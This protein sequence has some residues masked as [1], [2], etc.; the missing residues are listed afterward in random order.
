MAKM[1]FDLKNFKHVKSD[2][3]STVLQHKQGHELKIAHKNL[4]PEFKAQLDALAKVSQDSET[5]LQQDEMM[6]KASGGPIKPMSMPASETAM[7][8]EGGKVPI[9]A[10][11]PGPEPS[12]EEKMKNITSGGKKADEKGG[13]PAD[14]PVK[15]GDWSHIWK[16]DGGKVYMD[17]GGRVPVPSSG[18]ENDPNANNRQVAKKAPSMGGVDPSS[19]LATGDWSHIWKAE[20]GEVNPKLEQSKE[21]P[22]ENVIDYSKF[23]RQP[24]AEGGTLDYKKLKEEKRE[25]NRNEPATRR[26][27][28][29]DGG[30]VCEHCGGPIKHLADGDPD[31]GGVR[32]V[33]PEPL[34]EEAPDSISHKAIEN[35]YEDIV[36]GHNAGFFA[37]PEDHSGVS[38]TRAALPGPNGEPPVSPD[39]QALQQAK[40]EYHQEQAASAQQLADQA[41][42]AQKA[43][44]AGQ[45]FGAAPQP[46]DIA[47]ESTGGIDQ[48]QSPQPLQSG[49]QNQPPQD[50]SQQQQM[51]GTGGYQ[52]AI[53]QAADIQKKQLGDV[54]A[55][56][57][58]AMGVWQNQQAESENERQNH[59]KDI[60][61][62]YVDPNKYWQDHSKVAAGIGM[63]LAG[64]NPTS[65]PNAAIEFLN[66]QI[67][68]SIDAQKSNLN[69]KDNLL[70]ANLEHYRDMHSAMLMTNA[71]MND[72]LAAQMQKAGLEA[73]NPLARQAA[74]GAAGQAIQQAA[75]FQ[76]QLD[77]Q[78]TMMKLAGGGGSPESQAQAIAMMSAVNPEQAKAYRDAFVPEIGMSKSLTPIPEEVRQNLLAHHKLAT[79][80]QDLQQFVKSHPKAM[81]PGTQDYNVAAQKATILQAMIREPLLKTVYREGE[82]PVLDKLLKSPAGNL[83]SSYNT[84]PQLRNLLES[85]AMQESQLRQSYGLPSSQRQQEPQYKTV[86]G[87][88]YMRGPNGEP[89]RVK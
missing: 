3:D 56:R 27:R 78:Q 83:L 28:M 33:L 31:I 42:K 21:T 18:T 89:I 4:S 11:S 82:Q 85:N 7:Y 54:I 68:R 30:E 84:M 17:D 41:L 45:F 72:T 60:Q 39:P 25:I 23:K 77:M 6:H 58:Q 46:L 48:S 75:M 15:T 50:Q 35:K 12:P 66:N 13:P 44:Q 34:P 47:S 62:G 1:N 71:M 16:A 5:P 29:A 22:P 37:D 9:P 86:K 2:K 57:Q 10:P 51:L 88:K 53:R 79:A 74:L 38:K 55:A 64:F 26:K 32:Q 43:N 65:R 49:D 76:R 67:N 36:K 20:G 24:P 69:A 14:S 19:P 40:D 81:I 70:R 8:D 80:D 59:I 63:I 87:V 61:N 73:K 52:D